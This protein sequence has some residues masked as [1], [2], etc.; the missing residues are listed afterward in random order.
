MAKATTVAATPIGQG[1]PAKPRL[2]PTVTTGL[3]SLNSL[4]GIILDMND[5]E[6]DCY[7]ALGTHMPDYGLG[8][9][10]LYLLYTTADFVISFITYIQLPPCFNIMKTNLLD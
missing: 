5:L 1:I 8:P 9:T 6:A 4:N 10:Y 7:L 2:S 3:D